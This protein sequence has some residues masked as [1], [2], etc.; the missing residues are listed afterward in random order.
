MA[1]I[2]IY[3]CLCD[4][5]RLRILNLLS[6][7]PL[8]VCHFQELLNEPQVKVSKHLAYLR[9]HGCVE[10]YRYE[11]WTI[12][13]LPKNPSRELNAN[14]KCLQDCVTSDKR[15]LKDL[16]ALK[17]IKPETKWVNKVCCSKAKAGC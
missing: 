9:S 4:E 16:A 14:L 2:N 3:Q 7:G 6:Y 17:K 15:F 12:Y 8:C 5:T 10:S 13:S 1:L 11:N